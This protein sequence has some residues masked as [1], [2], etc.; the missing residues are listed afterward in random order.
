MVGDRSSGYQTAGCAVMCGNSLL[1]PI[2]LIHRRLSSVCD[3][4]LSCFRRCLKGFFH[5]PS[6]LSRKTAKHI[7]RQIHSGRLSPYAYLNPGKFLG[8]Q[9]GNDVL[10]SIMSS[11]AAL[12]ADPELSRLQTDIVIY[13]N[14]M[15]RIDFVEIRRLPDT[16]TA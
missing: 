16:F 8:S 9:M 3:H 5:H 4:H 13:Y 11:G 2:K 14:D 15:L 10:Y 12:S 7:V 6:V 1:M